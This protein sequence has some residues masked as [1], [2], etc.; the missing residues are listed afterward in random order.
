MVLA[1]GTL[2]YRPRFGAPLYLQAGEVACVLPPIRT[3]HRPADRDLEA[4]VG[5]RTVS[6]VFHWLDLRDLRHADRLRV[7]VLL[8]ACEV[9]AGRGKSRANAHAGRGGRR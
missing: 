2:E 6:G 9:S 1:R 7:R 5:L 3:G 4:Q 8:E